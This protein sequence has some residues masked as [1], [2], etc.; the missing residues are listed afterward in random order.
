VYKQI[1]NNAKLQIGEIGQKAELSGKSP[2][3]DEG[4]HWT[5]EPSKKKRK[6]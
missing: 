1:L 6:F 3:R 5:V 4:L 2:L